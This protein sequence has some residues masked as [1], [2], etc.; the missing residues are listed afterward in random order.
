M[1]NE[2]SEFSIAAAPVKAGALAWYCVLCAFPAAAQVPPP[3][4]V[5][6]EEIPPPEKPHLESPRTAEEV[7]VKRRVVP[8]VR[9]AYT[10]D[11]SRAGV[12][13][14]PEKGQE[15][16]CIGDVCV[17]ES[18]VAYPELISRR[19]NADEARDNALTLINENL[20]TLSREFRCD[21]GLMSA[22]LDYE[23]VRHDADIITFLF[24]YHLRPAGAKESAPREMR[25][26]YSL[27]DGSEVPQENNANTL[28]ER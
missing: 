24:R 28:Q 23:V 8:I 17:C 18:S 15:S 9:V 10:Y 11:Y 13:P 1:I 14:S 27:E 19:E 4:P 6:Q 16:G 22:A 26:T 3:E 2:R 12:A 20:D 25:V 21:E 7:E 5:M